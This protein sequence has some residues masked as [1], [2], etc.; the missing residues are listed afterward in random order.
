[1]VNERVTELAIPMD[2]Y[3]SPVCAF[4]TSGD[5]PVVV[6]VNEAFETAFGSVDSTDSIVEV[7]D[8]AGLTLTDNT[9]VADQLTTSDSFTARTDDDRYRVETIPPT[10][11][12]DGYLLFTET[13]DQEQFG[14]ENV[15]SVISH[16][17]RNPLDVAKSR[18]RAGRE[19]DEEEHFEHVA[20]AH[21]RMERIIQDVLTLARGQDV[22]DPDETVDLDTVAREAWETVETETGTLTVDG[23]LPTTVADSDRVSRLFENLFRNSVE[24]GPG[25][26]ESVTG[27]QTDPLT[28]TVG[29]LDD[30]SAAGFYV[31]DDGVGIPASERDH[32]FEPGYSSDDHGTG[33]GL[34]IVARIA[35]L[36]GWSCS[37]T[38]GTDGG[39]RIEIRGLDS[40]E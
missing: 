23:P 18:L 7:F 19:F 9:T 34:A 16:D 32:V 38:E 37:V 12:A 33:L 39:A 28:V 31:E 29:T 22:V 1:M 21:D 40:P 35:D 27:Q 17:L 20:R 10:D 6:E 15:A 30:A 5:G 11:D 24:H 26:D 36:H 14:V 25:G 8:D 13:T 2:R 3:P 4:T